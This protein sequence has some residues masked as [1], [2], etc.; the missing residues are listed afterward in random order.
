MTINAFPFFSWTHEIDYWRL[1]VGVWPIYAQ[2]SS[3]GDRT[4]VF[5]FRP[6]KAYPVMRLDRLE[7]LM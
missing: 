7:W 5:C 4:L 2:C 1:T 6:S 3:T